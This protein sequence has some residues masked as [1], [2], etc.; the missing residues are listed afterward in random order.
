MVASAPKP[1]RRPAQ[2]RRLTRSLS[3]RPLLLSDRARGMRLEAAADRLDDE[4]L[5]V[6]E[7]GRTGRQDL[8]DPAREDLLDRP[9]EGHR[10]ELRGDV[11]A[12]RAVALAG[13]DDLGD[14][15]VGLADLGEMARTEA[16][17]GARDLDDDH[18]H[19]VGVVA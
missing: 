14:A 3:I 7:L 6:L 15:R 5:R 16:V 9:V 19:Q 8:E 17:R 18:L 2:A 12:E 13:L 1:D 10:G 4:G 11:G